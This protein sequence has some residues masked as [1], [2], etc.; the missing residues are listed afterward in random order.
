MLKSSKGVKYFAPIGNSGYAEAAKDYMIGLID[1]DINITFNY[2]KFDETDIHINNTKRNEKVNTIINKDIDF[3]TI[4]VHSTPEH[5]PDIFRQYPN[6][7]KIGMTVWE[8]TKLHPEWV[9]YI[10]MADEVIVPCHWNK[11]VF[12]K[13]GVYKNISI[14]PHIIKKHNKVESHIEGVEDDD[15]VFYTIGQWHNRKG[16]GDAIKAY[17][18]EFNSKDNV[19]FI[20]KTFASNFTDIEKDKIKNRVYNIVKGYE[21]PAKIIL[22]IDEL[23]QQQI[24]AIHTKGDCY[25]S[26]CKSEGWGLGAFD[27]AGRGKAVIMTN[28][29]GQLDFLKNGNQKLVDYSLIPCEGMHWIKWYEKDQS[30]AQPNINQASKYMRENYELKLNYSYSQEK[31][32]KNNFNY[33]KITQ[34][35]IKIIWK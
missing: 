13:S 2:F 23:T 30:W 7:R 26:L 34:D 31:W 10:N 19:K 9:N 21:D 24:D 11:D 16:I 5:W 28:F 15:Y 6:K 18:N 8:T 35:L 1:A 3:D 25:V 4:L 17:L 22:I 20:I 33:E 12:K 27:A 14:I 29:G 32:I